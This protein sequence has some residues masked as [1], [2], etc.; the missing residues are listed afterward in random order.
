MQAYHEEVKRFAK[1]T[2]ADLIRHR[3]QSVTVAGMLLSVRKITTKSGRRM[4][5]ATIED[6][7]GRTEVAIFSKLYD[8]VIHLLEADQVLI[9]KAKVED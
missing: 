7:T 8:S 2:I 3:G 5:I 9:I 4:A 6:Q 1:S